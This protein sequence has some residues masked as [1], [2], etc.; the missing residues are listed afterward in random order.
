[1]EVSLETKATRLYIQR[2]LR[3]CPVE[4]CVSVDSPGASQQMEQM[5]KMWWYIHGGISIQS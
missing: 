2:T 1:M 5:K 3:K 4:M